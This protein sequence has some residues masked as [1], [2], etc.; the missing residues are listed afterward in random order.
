MTGECSEIL[1]RWS[2][3]S[4]EIPSISLLFDISLCCSLIP[5]ELCY[6]SNVSSETPNFLGLEL[7]KRRCWARSFA[8]SVVIRP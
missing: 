8:F 1:L 4:I 6:G 3:S 5:L 7:R 2:I